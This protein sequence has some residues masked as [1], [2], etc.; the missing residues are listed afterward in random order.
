M[1]KCDASIAAVAC[2]F[3]QKDSSNKSY[4]KNIKFTVTIDAKG[5]HVGITEIEC[6]AVFHGLIALR[7]LN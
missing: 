3:E 1:L 4:V 5:A 7:H 6:L 2:V